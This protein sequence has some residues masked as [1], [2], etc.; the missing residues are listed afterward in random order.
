VSFDSSRGFE[1]KKAVEEWK[2]AKPILLKDTGV[3]ELL[4]TLPESPAPG[5]LSA[6]VEVQGKLKLKIADPKIKKET[7]AVK[8]IESI[9]NDITAYL[10]WYKDRRTHVIS[11]WRCFCRQSKP[12]RRL[13][14]QLRL[15]LISCERH[16]Q[17]PLR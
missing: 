17:T 16:T 11:V 3:S 1:S 15:S 2:K 5:Q 8:C 14:K 7:K 10:K 12:V 4:R 9:H 13:W 6:Y